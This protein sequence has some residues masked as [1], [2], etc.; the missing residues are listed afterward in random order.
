MSGDSA[1]LSALKWNQVSPVGPS[2][3]IFPVEIL[4]LL[5]GGWQDGDALLKSITGSFINIKCKA[6]YIDCNL[7]SLQHHKSQDEA[8]KPGLVV[9]DVFWKYNQLATPDLYICISLY[10][11]Q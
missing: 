2:L 11:D 5:A 1:I 7:T 10:Q 3:Q 8:I 9:K 6:A 4:M